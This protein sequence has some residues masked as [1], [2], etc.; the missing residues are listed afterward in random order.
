[1][2][3]KIL[4]LALV[5]ASTS[6]LGAADDGMGCDEGALPTAQQIELSL[7][8]ELTNCPG[9][10]VSPGINAT[11]QQT[12]VYITKLYNVAQSCSR[13]NRALGVMLK[14]YDAQAKRLMAKYQ[15]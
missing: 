3:K 4:T 11:K 5:V 8:S 12:A 7:P 13:N 14:R 1:M 9:L 10:P 15:K 6:L 2:L